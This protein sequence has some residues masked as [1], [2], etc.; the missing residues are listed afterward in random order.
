M[1]GAGQERRI[2]PTPRMAASI[3]RRFYSKS[4]GIKERL[5][6]SVSFYGN[7]RSFSL[8]KNL[9]LGVDW[10]TWLLVNAERGGNDWVTATERKHQEGEGGAVSDDTW[11]DAPF[12]TGRGGIQ[13][14]PVLASPQESSSTFSPE[15]THV[16]SYPITRKVYFTY[17]YGSEE[18]ERGK[19]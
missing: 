8:R 5:L 13:T 14:L 10:F 17:F 9:G 3:S 16:V 2:S 11:N 1:L 4:Y 15:Y 19:K 18:E 12:H 6:E 7:H